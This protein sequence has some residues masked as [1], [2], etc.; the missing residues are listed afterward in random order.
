MLEQSGKRELDYLISH[1]SQNDSKERYRRIK[2]RIKSYSE[3]DTS[4]Y[5]EIADKFI[6]NAERAE[7]SSIVRKAG[8]GDRHRILELME[9]LKNGDF[10]PG[11]LKEYNDELYRQLREIDTETVRRICPDISALDVEDGIRVMQEI[12]A[13]DILQEIKSE[14]TALIDRRLTRMKT[15]ESIQLVEKLKRSL[16]KNIEDS[17][18]IHYYDARKMQEGENTDDESIL[19]RNA[20]S[21]YAVLLGRYEY[22]VMICDSSL[23]GNGKDGFIIT[24]DHIFYKGIVKSGKLDVMDIEEICLDSGKTGK[25]IFINKTSGVKLKLPCPLKGKDQRNMAVALNDFATYLKAKPKSRSIEYMSQ[26][27][28]A[29]I[30]CYRCGHVF[31]EGTICPK[32]GSRN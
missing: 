11:I 1:I 25:A 18:R 19:I 10:D 6:Q 8:T 21:K 15:E 32:C 3:I 23:F 17:T 26:E 30:C 13:A 4:K 28:H 20:I 5:E 27:K 7:L 31:K 29:T 22:P 9:S 16:D 14:M 2:E 12:E 24:P